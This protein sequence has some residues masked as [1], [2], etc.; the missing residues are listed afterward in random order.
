MKELIEKYDDKLIINQPE[1][2]PVSDWVD[3][4]N[5]NQLEKE[6]QNYINFKDI[7]LERLLGYELED[8]EFEH[9]PGNEG[10][11]VEFTLKQKDKEYVVVETKGT[12]T[13][14]LNKRYNREQSAIEQATNYASIKKETEWA[15]V[16]NYDEFMLFNPNYREQYISF[17]FRE[18][19]N[20]NVLK[21][22]LLTFSKFS[23]IENEL[24]KK[25]L[26][27]TKLLEERLE[28]EFYE[29]FSETRLMI[30]KELEYSGIKKDEAIRYS[31]LI[32]N[33]YIFIC[34]AEDIGLLPSGTSIDTIATPIQHK[35]LFEFAI[36]EQLNELFRFIDK[37][38]PTKEISEFNGGLFKENLRNL[39]IRDFI[40]DLDFYNDCKRKW[41]FEKKYI[42]IEK[43][44]EDYKNNLNP[45]YRN[46]LV[47]SSFDFDS[48]LDVNILGHI[49]E[50]SIGDIEELKN[51]SKKRR[52]Q[53]GVF[54][55]PEYVTDYICK[56]TIIP[57]L[58]KEGDIFSVNDLINE[59]DDDILTLDKKIRDIKI[60]DVTC[61]SGAFL[62]KAADI[63]LE[64]HEAIFNKTVDNTLDAWFDSITERR[65]ILLNNIYGVDLNEESVDN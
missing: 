17:N 63:L 55:T 60:I 53:D 35:N 30:I 54:Y 14:N 9:D 41:K 64:I 6:K 21:E 24:P 51:Q 16:T 29:L 49:F 50:N 56:N 45:I 39:E 65:E 20:E 27:E 43:L 57:Y 36:W 62:N 42:Q 19:E 38:N 31:Q 15:I 34:F 13:K 37:G 46:L 61:G 4:L 48:E 44:I 22:F 58:S 23:L 5:Q 28:D 59:Y 12:K 40:D 18:L 11:P 33:R 47:I 7:I 1:T 10:R 25:L 32:L 52:K 8:L 3:K 26:T 2:N